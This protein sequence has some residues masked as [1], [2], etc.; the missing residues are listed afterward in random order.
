[1]RHVFAVTTLS[2]AAVALSA[3]GTTKT[4]T[5]TVT[6]TLTTATQANTT[7]AAASTTQTTST[8]STTTTQANSESKTCSVNGVNAVKGGKVSVK[9][10]ASGYTAQT[11]RLVGC[12]TATDLVNIVAGKKSQMPVKTNNFQCTPT[13]T[14]SATDYTCSLSAKDKGKVDYQ[15]TL[16]YS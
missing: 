10:T 11:A 15:F 2:L 5:S 13:V 1:M 3:C 7:T 16:N 9:L 8:A 4:V 12:T 14:G 6:S